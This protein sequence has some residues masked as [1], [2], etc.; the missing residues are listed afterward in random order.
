M[1]N[2]FDDGRK[3]VTNEKTEKKRKIIKK[4]IE[5]LGKKKGM[6]DSYKTHRRAT[7]R[8]TKK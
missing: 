8:L 1:C 7:Y 3:L 2:G 5:T 4:S 6:E